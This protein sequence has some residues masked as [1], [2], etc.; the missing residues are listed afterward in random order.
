MNHSG[1]DEFAHGV[2]QAIH[3]DTPQHRGNSYSFRG[4]DRNYTQCNVV[5]FYVFETIHMFDNWNP[6]NFGEKDENLEHERKFIDY[7]ICQQGSTY[8]RTD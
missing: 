6:A 1:C 5:F 2:E 7:K 4:N 8:E 3:F